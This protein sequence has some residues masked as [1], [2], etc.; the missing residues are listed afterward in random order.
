MNLARLPAG[1]WSSQRRWRSP[2]DEF[3]FDLEGAV[4]LI[5]DGRETTLRRGDAAAFP[6]GTGDGR[7]MVNRSGVDGWIWRSDLGVLR[8][9]PS[10]QTWT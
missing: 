1:T 4:V 2:V 5:D 9:S 3:A 8:T 7:H 10:A 6:G